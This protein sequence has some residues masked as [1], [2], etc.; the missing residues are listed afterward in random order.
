MYKIPAFRK[1]LF[2]RLF[3]SGHLFQMYSW[4]WRILFFF[5]FI[6]LKLKKQ[7]FYFFYFCL[8]TSEQ[9]LPSLPVHDQGIQ[10]GLSSLV[11]APA[12]SHCPITLLSFTAGAALLHGIQHWAA[13][14]Q[15]APRYSVKHQTTI[16]QPGRTQHTPSPTDFH[17]WFLSSAAVYCY[18]YIHAFQLVFNLYSR[19]TCLSRFIPHK[20]R[21]RD[22]EHLVTDPPSDHGGIKLP[23]GRNVNSL[24]SNSQ[25]TVL[26]SAG[27]YRECLNLIYLFRICLHLLFVRNV[28][29]S[30]NYDLI[31]FVISVFLTWKMQLNER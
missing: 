27:Y 9:F 18:I 22:D 5:L 29:V 1:Y 20:Q 8:E 31:R 25:T 3:A 14:L 26:S 15:G 17:I 4:C 28:L 11:W 24:L 2:T 6:A 12:I 7:N 30:G 16:L 10:R 21:T 19:Y 23:T 13:W